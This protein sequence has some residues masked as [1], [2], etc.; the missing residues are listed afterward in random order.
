[1]ST[2]ELTRPPV[3]PSDPDPNASWR[4]ARETARALMARR[5]RHLRVMW[6]RRTVVGA[7]AMLASVGV[8]IASLWNLGSP[9]VGEPV[10]ALVWGVLLT[11][12]SAAA[13]GAVYVLVRAARWFA[14][15]WRMRTRLRDALS[16][17][18]YLVDERFAQRMSSTFASPDRWWSDASAEA[19]EES[20]DTIEF[21][22][23]RALLTVR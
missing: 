10:D 8:V 18:A 14:A 12:R 22:I 4:V 13:V 9:T 3:R 21:E 6:L 1:M 5:H 17:A 16:D 7:T 2:T 15:P 19:A 23:E 11:V 20:L